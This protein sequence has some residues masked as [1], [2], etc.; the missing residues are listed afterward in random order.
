MPI[1]FLCSQCHHPIEVDD[2]YRGQ[3]AACPYC[4][5]HVTVPTESTYDA[6]APVPARPVPPDAPGGETRVPPLRTESDRAQT[7]RAYGRYALGAAVVMLLLLGISLV[8]GLSVMLSELGGVPAEPLTPEQNEKLQ[9]ALA[10]HPLVMIL[11]LA[12]MLFALVGFSLAIVSL[13]HGTDRRRSSIG[14]LLL[15]GAFLFCNCGL[16]LLRPIAG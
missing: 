10:T 16:A 11:S 7:A 5:A 4:H 12:S 8:V 9:E 15:C 1:Q 2:E 6:T 3:A 14:V 13:V